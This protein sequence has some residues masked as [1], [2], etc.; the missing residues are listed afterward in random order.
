M[1]SNTRQSPVGMSSEL[2]PD[3]KDR[4]NTIEFYLQAYQSYIEQCIDYTDL[5]AGFHLFSNG[6]RV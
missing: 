4:E 6:N 3:E 1:A 2:E 5:I